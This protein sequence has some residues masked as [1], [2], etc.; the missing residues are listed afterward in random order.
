M[1]YAMQVCNVLEACKIQ[2]VLC[3]CPVP[4]LGGLAKGAIQN[5]L[6]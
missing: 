3:G 2:S 4:L 5:Y 1:Y 6:L